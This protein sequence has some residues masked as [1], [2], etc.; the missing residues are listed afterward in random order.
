[1][2]PTIYKPSIYKGAGIYKSGAEGGEFSELPDISVNGKIFKNF[3]PYS[4]Y[5][6]RDNIDS[7]FILRNSWTASNPIILFGGSNF[8]LIENDNFEIQFCVSRPS[9]STNYSSV[10]GSM[11][12]WYDNI[13]MDFGQV[14]GTI[15][16]LFVGIPRSNSPNTWLDPLI[17]DDIKVSENIFYKIKVVCNDTN[18]TLSITD[19]ES[20]KSVNTNKNNLNADSILQLMGLNRN[21]S[22][23][24]NGLIDLKSSYIKKNG[25]LVWG[26]DG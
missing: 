17:I 15:K 24:F 9:F 2:E 3:F 10:F 22:K 8:Q 1:M 26:M 11:S 4:T 16:K 19:N 14:S 5:G 23:K 12:Y 7:N 21:E 25:V 20:M 13:S 6:D 18:I